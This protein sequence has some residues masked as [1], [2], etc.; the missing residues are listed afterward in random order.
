[1]R[2]AVEED[3]AYLFGWKCGVKPEDMPDRGYGAVS[4]DPAGS[5]DIFRGYR[6]LPSDIAVLEI[7]SH[8]PRG[9]VSPKTRSL[10]RCD[11]ADRVP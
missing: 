1:M 7:A 8:E 11:V 3:I 10:A 5:A 4:M 2:M 6:V 9:A